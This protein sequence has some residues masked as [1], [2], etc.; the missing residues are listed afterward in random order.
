MGPTNPPRQYAADDEER[1]RL[2]VKNSPDMVFR[3]TVEGVHQE[4][5]AAGAALLGRP[6][7]EIVGTSAE[8]WVHPGDVE[9]FDW[10]E[11][12]LLRDG[13]VVV[14]LRLRHA[15]RH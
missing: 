7:E 10:A 3:R 9:E 2:L 8:S 5:S 15:D 4:V 13:R 12:D 11:R 14:C 1:F 6:V